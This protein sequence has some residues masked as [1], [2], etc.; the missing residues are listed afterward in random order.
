MLMYEAAPLMEPVE[1][2]LSALLVVCTRGL[3]ERALLP[4]VLH[5]LVPADRVTLLLSSACHLS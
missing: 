2:K 3:Q 4:L 1:L 5:V